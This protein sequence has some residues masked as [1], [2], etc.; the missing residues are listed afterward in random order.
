MK[1]FIRLIGLL[2]VSD[3]S[4]GPVVQDVVYEANV[5]AT[6]TNCADAV[7]KCE[8]EYFYDDQERRDMLAGIRELTDWLNNKVATLLRR[9]IITRLPLRVVI[10]YCWRPGRWKSLT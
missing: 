7:A 3:T 4:T 8:P 6:N 2:V 1:P 9:L 10:Q 5:T